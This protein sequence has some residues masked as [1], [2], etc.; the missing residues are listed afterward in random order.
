MKIIDTTTFFEENMMMDIR[1]NVLNPYIDK[2]IICESKYTHSGKE[3]KIN[4][5]ANDYPKFKDK[6]IHLVLE[7]EPDSLIKKKNL[8]VQEKRLNSIYRIR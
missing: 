8:S 2:F 3:K 4:F 7:K 1:F 5:N 6:I